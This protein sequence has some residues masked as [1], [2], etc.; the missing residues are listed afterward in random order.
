[1]SENELALLLIVLSCLGGGWGAHRAGQPAWKGFLIILVAAVVSWGALALIGSE[2]TILSI[3][4]SLVAAGALGGAMKMTGPQIGMVI[5][6]SIVIL[7][8][9][10]VLVD[11]AT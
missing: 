6:G 11:L 2:S 9:A 3:V 1:M 8:P 5:L 4:I 10:F 7:I